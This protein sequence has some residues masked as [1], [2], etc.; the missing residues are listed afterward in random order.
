MCNRDSGT[1]LCLCHSLT[2]LLCRWGPADIDVAVAKPPVV[3]EKEAS[4]L[5]LGS[6]FQVSLISMHLIRVGFGVRGVDQSGVGSRVRKHS[7]GCCYTLGFARRNTLC[8][9]TNRANQTS[10]HTD[11]GH[12][13]PMY[14]AIT[15]G[16]SH[17]PMA[18]AP[19]GM[20]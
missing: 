11:Q 17:A 7:L 19:R 20:H 10:S 13:C 3:R 12:M 8:F 9:P 6:G 14:V 15:Q 16:G 4:R 18:A 1:L 2:L 5:C